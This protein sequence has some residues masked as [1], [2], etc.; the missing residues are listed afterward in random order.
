MAE[1]TSKLTIPGADPQQ[2]AGMTDYQADA[3]VS[4]TLIQNDS[5]ILTVFSF[6]KG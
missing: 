6:D 5:G 4:R 3:I 2:L 1:T